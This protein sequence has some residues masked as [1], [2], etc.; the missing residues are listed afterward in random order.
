MKKRT[1]Y[2]LPK[3]TEVTGAIISQLIKTHKTDVET[4]ARLESYADDEPVMTRD[5][6]NE[7]LAIHNFAQYITSIN[8]GYLLGNPVDYKAADSTVL[9][10]IVN[11]YRDQTIYDLDADLGNDCSMFG[12]AFENVFVDENAEILSAKLSPYNTIV[13]YD[14]TFKHE[15]MFAVYYANQLDAQGNPITE[16][17]ELTIWTP[18]EIV[19]CKLE[20]GNFLDEVRKAHVF[21]AVPV[22]HYF[23][24][25]RLK[26]DYEPV[27]SLIDAYNILQSDRVIDREKLV[28][29]ILAF[30]GS[31]LSAEDQQAIKDNRV[32]GL[33]EGSKAEYI[34]K[35]VNEA[36]ADVLRQTIAAD[37]HKFSMTPDLTDETFGNAPSGVSILYKLL[38][39]ENNIKNKE[40]MF[41]T[42]LKT[43]FALYVEALKTASKLGGDIDLKEIDVVFRRALPK[44]DFETSQMINNLDGTVDSETL[45]GQLS[46]VDDASSV[47]EKVKKEREAN[48]IAAGFGTS[49]PNPG[50][51]E[52]E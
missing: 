29:A 1:I 45:V 24:N 11:V 22:V 32:V 41:E 12:Q 42:G 23:N 50:E 43:R 38:A 17:Y 21:K 48:V 26:G 37:I 18:A 16:K 28:D 36:D 8:T 49:N 10:P 30:Y 31:R 7:L 13:V 3:D 33:P 44:N 5:A 40:R 2:T 51:V 52:D 14:N 9:D 35:Q 34:V 25:K 19:E 46:F 15:K 39:F 20:K 27:L 6:P 4:F 47:V